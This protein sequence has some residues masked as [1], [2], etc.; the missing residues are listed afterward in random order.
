MAEFIGILFLIVVS[1]MSGYYIGFNNG[2]SEFKKIFKR[3]FGDTEK[4]KLAE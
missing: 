1:Y 3:T 2:F 4:E